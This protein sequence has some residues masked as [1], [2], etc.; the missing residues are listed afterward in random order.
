V[1][2]A[3]GARQPVVAVWTGNYI[4]G[5]GRRHAVLAHEDGAAYR[6]DWLEYELVG[7]DVNRHRIASR[8]CAELL[9]QRALCA[10]GGEPRLCGPD[11]A[12]RTERLEFGCVPAAEAAVRP[13]CDEPLTLAE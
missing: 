11:R 12:H 13:V 5:V 8:G 9:D 3:A 10:S 2:E 4:D 6:I 1:L 7:L